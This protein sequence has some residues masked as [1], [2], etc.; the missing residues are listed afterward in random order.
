MLGLIRLV[1]PNARIIHVRRDPLDNCLSM[2]KSNFA[3]ELLAFSFDLAELG[4]YYNL[5]RG[6]MQHWRTVLP[7]QFFEIDYEALVTEPEVTTKAL[8]QYCGL[9]WSPDVLE[10]ADNRREV[11]TMSFAQVRQPIHAGSVSAAARYGSKL[12]PLRAALA[13]WDEAHS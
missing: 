12:D 1:F 9:D 4:R 3:S 10:I 8:F 13:E 11:R 2:F 6:L 7:G 5:Y